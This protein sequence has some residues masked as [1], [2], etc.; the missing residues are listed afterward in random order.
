MT[1]LESLQDVSVLVLPENH[2]IKPF[3]FEDDDFHEFLFE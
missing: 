1:L 2:S 3:D